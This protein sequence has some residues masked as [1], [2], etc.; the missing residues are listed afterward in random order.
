MA[1]GTPDEVAARWAQALAGSTERIKQGIMA[2][3]VAPGQAAA[4]QADV[5]AQNVAASRGKWARNV[6]SVSLQQWQ[7]AAANKGT[8][9]IAAGAQQAQPKMASFLSRFLPYVDSQRQQLPPRGN[10]DQNIARMT[11]WVRAMSNFNNRQG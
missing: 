4:R 1:H 10:I 6:A 3:Q 9:R 5:W 7:E 11:A 8:Q 2:V